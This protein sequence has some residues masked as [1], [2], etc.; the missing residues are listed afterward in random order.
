MTP[1]LHISK[2]LPDHEALNV[3][4]EEYIDLER[5]ANGAVVRKRGVA[6]MSEAGRY[7][8]NQYLGM[9][10]GFYVDGFRLGH[11]VA[12]IARIAVAEMLEAYHA[13]GR[14]AVLILRK[15]QQMEIDRKH[16]ASLE[17]IKPRP[18]LNELRARRAA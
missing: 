15:W 6:Q 17:K 10:L 16:K 12:P 9:S 11:K 5:D 2:A 14:Q 18:T 4:I 13:G 8:L 3:F 7:Q 1:D